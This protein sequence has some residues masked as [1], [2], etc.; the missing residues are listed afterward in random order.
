MAVNVARLGKPLLYNYRYDQL[1]RL[2]N[3]DSWRSSGIT[4]SSLTKILDYRESVAYD[5]M[6][7][8]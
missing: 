8:Y 2:V 3:M 6:A 1:N 7:T 5:A 4:W